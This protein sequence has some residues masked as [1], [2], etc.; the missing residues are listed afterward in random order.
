MFKG[1]RARE[2]LFVALMWLVSI[3]LAG[4]L[5]GLGSLVIGDLP[6]VSEPV[7]V[8]DFIPAG[9]LDAVERERNRLRAALPGT[10][11]RLADAETAFTQARDSYASERETFDNWILT[12]AAT[13]NSAQNPEVVSRSR[14]L[15][16]LK[17]RERAAQATR[18]AA[19]A[20]ISQIERAMTAQTTVENQ[21]RKAATP[22]YER[23]A[24]LQELKVFG[25]R[26]ALT[27]PLLLV[28]LWML[29]KGRGGDYWP[30]KRGFI[31]FAA[32]AFFVELVPYLPDY[33][34]Y[35]RYGVGI[36]V[37]LVVGHYVIKW[38]RAYLAGREADESRAEVERVRSIEY[39]EALK[40]KA[41]NACP[42][43]DRT[44]PAAEGAPIDYCVHCGMH[45]FNHCPTCKTRKFAFFRY[46]MACGTPATTE[47]AA[48]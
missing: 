35:I 12:R 41:A 36:L 47:S 4:F 6:K 23:A 5:I 28:A 18:D 38:M 17:A 32:F 26:L 30:M 39:D 10:R 19:Q 11:T 46:C 34:G 16:R 22:A 43:C 8:E 27:L 25:M 20:Q 24:F 44:L 7:T 15:D 2:N 40:K 9:R 3:V 29:L 33:G 1:A 14:E 21:L 13:E 31:L 45:L 42:G 48:R 37:T